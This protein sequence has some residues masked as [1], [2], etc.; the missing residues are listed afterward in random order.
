MGLR[1][2][3]SGSVKIDRVAVPWEDALGWDP[4][5]KKP[6]AELLN[7]PWASLLLPT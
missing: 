6:L 5:T 7:I 2:T 3:E 4:K 1:L